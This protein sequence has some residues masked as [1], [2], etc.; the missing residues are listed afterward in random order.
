[1]ITF[2]QNEFI[3]FIAFVIPGMIAIK[4]YSLM[5]P[6]GYT[7]TSK[8]IMDAITYSCFNYAVL[9][10]PIY[11]IETCDIKTIHPDMYVLFYMFVLFIA[12]VITA[13]S[14]RN[15]REC[16]FIQKF[17]PHPTAKPWDH[18]FSKRQTHWMIVTLKNGNKIAGKYGPAS[19]VS[20]YPAEEQIYLEEEWVL[21]EDEGFDRMVEQTA[22][23]IIMPSEIALVELKK[24][25]KPENE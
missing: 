19:F 23:I 24:D 8:Q 5:S 22:G 25:G 1:M 21:N 3:L 12:P 9:L 7:E 10:W 4:T 6:S 11:K 13:I 18:V 16:D 20:S 17:A 15:F 2:E 14:W